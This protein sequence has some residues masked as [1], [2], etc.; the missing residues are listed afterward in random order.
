M[1]CLEV[2]SQKTLHIPNTVSQAQT[3]E[4]TVALCCH[5]QFQESPTCFLYIINMVVK[6]EAK[7]VLR[8][9]MPL[10]Q[11]REQFDWFPLWRQTKVGLAVILLFQSG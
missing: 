7:A 5:L 2:Q 3:A 11:T 6:D 8:E 10:Y 1:F 9:E 4:H